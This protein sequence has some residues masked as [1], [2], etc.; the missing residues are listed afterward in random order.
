MKNKFSKNW[1]R[2]KQPRKQRKF[3]ANAPRHI[4]HRFMSST[5]DKPLR[6]KYQT[7][8]IEIKKN[9]E[10]KIMRGKFSKKQGKVT[11]I[12]VNN[13]RIQVEGLNI[14]KKDGEK[15]PVWFH[16]SK[17]KITELEDSDK[18]RFKHFN[19]KTQ[20]KQEPK[21]QTNKQETKTKETKINKED[22]K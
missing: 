22:K 10:V 7:R 2:S 19:K 1:S 21:K 17:V 16:P 14:T 20:T 12:D 15:V 8:N 4:K 11:F 5:L 13:Q 9:D 3:L 18:K 6:E